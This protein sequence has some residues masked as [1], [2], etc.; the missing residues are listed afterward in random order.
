MPFI[1][2]P[3]FIALENMDRR[4]LEAA[5]D[6]GASRLAGAPRKVTLPIAAPGIVAAFLFVFIPSIGEY[7][8]PSLV[9]GNNGYMFGQ[10]IASQFVGGALNWQVGLGARDLPARRRALPHGRDVEVPPPGRRCDRVSRARRDVFMSRNGQAHAPVFFAGFLAF[11]YLPSILLVIFSFNASTVIA[12]PLTGF[13]TD[14]YEAAWQNHEIT[15]LAHREPQGRG[16]NGRDRDRARRPRLLRARP[17]DDAVQ[18]RRSRHSCSCPLVVPTVVFGVAL[19][20][21]FRPT[22]PMIP[23]PLGLWAVLIGHIVI[24]LPFCVLLLLPRIASIDQRL[25]EAAHDLGASGLTTFRRIILPLITSRAPRRRS[26]SP[27]SISI[28]EVVI[29]SF[30]VQDQT[31]YP[32]YLYSGLRLGGRTSLL[33]PVATVMLVVSFLLVSRGGAVRR[34]GERRVGLASMRARVTCVPPRSASA[35]A[36]AAAGRRS[37]APSPRPLRARPRPMPEGPERGRAEAPREARGRG[38]LQLHG[39]DR[40]R[41]TGSS[42][43]SRRS[44]PTASSSRVRLTQAGSRTSSIVEQCTPPPPF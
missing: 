15:R 1:V 30:L 12:F 32:V 9:G 21:L 36:P 19:L 41:A 4:L 7:I 6:L 24:A 10:A 40:A 25:E 37:N 27:S 16:G 35:L 20:V 39:R 8:T 29:A 17:A 22:D 13:T 38:R 5:T 43:G 33:M 3:I 23:I 31:T 18:G 14:W 28:D 34:I 42:A 2:L 11:L 44:A 26:S